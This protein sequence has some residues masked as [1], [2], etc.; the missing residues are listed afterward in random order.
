VGRRLAG[1]ALWAAALGVAAWG[2]LALW[3]A[4]PGPAV[5]RGALAGLA[6]G[7]A[8]G[9]RA[10]ARS[11]AR[12]A[13]AV[14]VVG[15]ALLAWW[16]TLRPSNARAWQP[17][18]ARTPTVQREGDRVT[19]RDVR[20]FEWRSET[21][22]T[23]R[24]VERRYDL[25]ALAGLDLFLSSWGSPHI[26][27]TILSFEFSDGQRL[28]ISIETRKEEGEAY[29]ALAG[30]FRRYERVYVAGEERDLVRLRTDVR[31]EAVRLYPLRVPLE[32]ARAILLDYLA[33]MNALA[34]EPDWYNALT[35]NCTTSIRQHAL[36]SG[37]RWPLDWRVFANGHL[38][39]LLYERGVVDTRLPFEA[40]RAASLVS[41]AGGGGAAF[42]ERIREGV[43]NPRA[44]APGSPAPGRGPGR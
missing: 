7:A 25:S 39:A 15:L 8:F 29:S 5:L 3:F 33:G 20:D 14:G 26:A 4:G 24:W 41:R 38:D 9:A 21:D 19:L 35:T 37:G 16:S 40:L 23:P 13:L 6:A 32:R 11:R 34:A 2:G 27:H 12:S 43:P 30:F 31:G 17:D 28:A 44:P 42:S 22:F 10:R 1:A 18:V 36:H